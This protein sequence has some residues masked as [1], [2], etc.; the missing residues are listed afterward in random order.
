M[1]EFTEDG[2]LNGRVRVRQPVLGFRSGLDAVMLA[3]AVPA[4]AGDTVL[5][6]GAGAGAASLCLAARVAGCS[7]TGVEQDGAL[8]ALAN[9]NAAANGMDARVRF[10][11]ADVLKLPRALRA[12]FDHVFCNPPFHGG[13]GEASPNTERSRALHEAGGLSRWLAVGVKRTTAKGTFTVVLRADRLSEAL[14]ALS[15]TGVSV[16]PLW[17]KA[18]VAAKRVIIQLDRGKRAPF[19]LLPGL[20]L[21]HKT[22]GYTPEADAILRCGEAV[23]VKPLTPLSR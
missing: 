6:L 10:V 15:R 22:G 20:V 4:R 8:V 14:D 17:P 19:A 1:T 2:F 7:I 16:L 11:E 18:G 12:D 5:E 21:H 23:S 3:A 13:G 9:A